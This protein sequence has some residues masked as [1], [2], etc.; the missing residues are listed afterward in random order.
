MPR[1]SCWTLSSR[2][3]HDTT[4]VYQNNSRAKIIKYLKC[5][6]MPTRLNGIFFSGTDILF[7]TLAPIRN[8]SLT[9]Q[10]A[11][12][13]LVSPS[14]SYH[15]SLSIC[16]FVLVPGIISTMTMEKSFPSQLGNC[17][18]SMSNMHFHFSENNILILVLGM[19][20]YLPFG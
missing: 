3:A 1:E 20:S 17:H 7:H 15:L 12:G 13:H 8:F 2:C 16:S 18:F 10:H 6:P 19:L 9:S 14:P 5:P 11:P 4:K